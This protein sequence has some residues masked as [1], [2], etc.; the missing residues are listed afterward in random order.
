MVQQGCHGRVEAIAVL[1]LQRQAFRQAPGKHPH[2]IEGLQLR[3]RGLDL[4]WLAPHHV[5]HRV[6]IRRQ[7]SGLV[8]HIHQVNPDYAIDGAVG[9]LAELCGQ[10]IFQGN[11]AGQ[12]LVHVEIVAAIIG[13]AAAGSYQAF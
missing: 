6:Q 12:R 10:V 3:Q 2:R 8:D 5:R 4:L 13:T 9:I 7:V 1:Q 11:F